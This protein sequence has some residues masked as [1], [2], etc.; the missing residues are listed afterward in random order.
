MK[1]N[2][3]KTIESKGFN[4]TLWNRAGKAMHTYQMIEHND[5]IAVGISGGKDSL[6][7]LNILL[8]TKLIVDFDFDIYPIYISYK[9]DISDISFVENYVASLGLTLIKKSTNIENIVFGTKNEKNPCSLCSR[10][11]RGVLYTMMKDL[12][13]KKLA[14][15]HHLDDIIETFLM[16]FF[17]QGNMKQ[18]KPTYTS[19]EYGFRI[20]RPMAYIDEKVIS[21][22]AKKIN[23]P[24]LESNCNY[25]DSKNSK[26]KKMKELIS[27]LEKENSDIRQ[28]AKRAL[29]L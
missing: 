1:K 15:G 14:L 3:L 29:N 24:I 12:N 21:K 26:R 5:K 20:I 22:Y 23:F 27:Y 4:K 19:D 2:I 6:T 16:N 11:R 17:Y 13:I 7:L 25:S 28:V 9:Q 10:L 8:R 18:M